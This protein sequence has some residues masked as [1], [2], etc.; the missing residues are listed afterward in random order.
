MVWPMVAAQGANALLNFAGARQ[1][2]KLAK[3]N[4]RLSEAQWRHA[5]GRDNQL[6]AEWQRSALPVLR[7]VAESAEISP[8]ERASYLG[9][10]AFNVDSAYDQAAGRMDRALAAYG[11]GSLGPGAMRQTELARAASRAGAL[12]ATERALDEASFNRQLSAGGLLSG[13]LRGGRASLMAAQHYGN[14]SAQHGAA[15]GQMYGAA[16]ESLGSAIGHLGDWWEKR[17]K[18]GE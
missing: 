1:Q 13:A 14:M 18:R 12:T 7:G 8:A 17:G 6:W 2:R 11:G 3:R 16:G 5:V 9:Q 15:A 10:A 4:A